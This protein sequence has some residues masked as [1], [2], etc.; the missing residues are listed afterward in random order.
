MTK[1]TFLL[2]AVVS[3]SGDGLRR[4]SAKNRMHELR[5]LTSLQSPH[6]LLLCASRT[7]GIKAYL[8]SSI[9][10]TY[11]TCILLGSGY[12][13]MFP[14]IMTATK[15]SM[16]EASKVSA[17]VALASA[18]G[19][20]GYSGWLVDKSGVNFAIASSLFALASCAVGI[21]LASKFD[22][23]LALVGATEFFFCPMWPAHV[24]RVRKSKSFA[25]NASGGIWQLGVA[26]RV[27]SVV[28]ALFYGWASGL[29]SWRATEAASAGVAVVALGLL[30]YSSL[31]ESEE[32]I[33]PPQGADE[34]NGLI[35]TGAQRVP[36]P[37]KLESVTVRGMLR[38]MACEPQFWL[39]AFGNGL[40]GVTKGTGSMFVA[41]YLRDRSAPGVVSESLCMQLAASFTSGVGLS[42]FFL[43]AWF[44]SASAVAKR[45]L[46]RVANAV[47]CLAMIAIAVDAEHVAESRTHLTVRVVLFFV[48]GIGIGL[49]YYIP[50]GLFS[51]RFGDVGA[52]TVSSFL[53]G[54]QYLMSFL[55]AQLVGQ[56]FSSGASWSEVWGLFAACYVAGAC[57][58]SAYLEPLL[59]S[60][61][62]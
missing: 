1:S 15:S 45:N 10:V 43:G 13:A 37:S 61:A 24:Q 60:E 26:S 55:V 6:K 39:A 4:R 38:K 54:M 21:S 40:L 33:F 52:G 49:S 18:V 36:L 29:W 19:K 17:V 30:G 25:G 53:D 23:I 14:A 58:T 3:M 9:A 51:I 2:C 35:P 46:V 56:L 48:S 5:G 20:F 7:V 41:I 28:S 11:A 8:P 59:R 42:V 32:H 12:S 22:T 44:S 50:P 16:V 34:G 47:S 62:Q 27:G 57:F 31:R